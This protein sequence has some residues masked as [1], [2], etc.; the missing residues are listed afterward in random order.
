MSR[1][2]RSAR[3]GGKRS[4]PKSHEQPVR[5]GRR[6]AQRVLCGCGNCSLAKPRTSS[7]PSFII[8]HFDQPASCRDCVKSPRAAENSRPGCD[9]RRASGLPCMEP[10][11]W[12]PVCH[13]RRGRPSSGLRDFSHSLGRMRTLLDDERLRH[14]SC[15]SAGVGRPVGRA[16]PELSSFCTRLA[17]SANI[18]IIGSANCRGRVSTMQSVPRQ[19]PFS[20]KSGKPA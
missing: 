3:R 1:G 11:G 6:V 18:W 8:R 2:G 20:A 9:G 12:K 19:L 16:G 7:V 14:S 5:A 10:T 17:R 4:D 15:H 13:D